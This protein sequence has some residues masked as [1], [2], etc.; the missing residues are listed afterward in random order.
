MDYDDEILKVFEMASKKGRKEISSE[1][2][3]ILTDI[4]EQTIHQKLESMSKY[5]I[6]K[7][8]KSPRNPKNFWKLV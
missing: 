5:G 8:V 4:P 3:V 2:I 6:I 1:A 7:N